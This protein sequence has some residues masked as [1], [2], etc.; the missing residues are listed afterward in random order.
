MDSAHSSLDSE[1]FQPQ[2][3]APS[4]PVTGQRVTLNA[5]QA[6][7]NNTADPKAAEV[8]RVSL[9]PERVVTLRCTSDASPG[10]NDVVEQN[11]RRFDS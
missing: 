2:K 11:N 6:A 3:N 10:W 1:A 8:V 5:K 7:S 9:F 4:T